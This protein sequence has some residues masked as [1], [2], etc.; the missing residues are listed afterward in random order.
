MP[1][2]KF[3]YAFGAGLAEGDGSMKELLGGKGA[4][5]HEMTKIGLP[6]PAGFTITT[7]VC[8]LYYKNGK[9]WPEGLEAE[10]QKHIKNLEKVTKKT[11]GDPRDPLLVSVRSGAP[12]SMPGMME[13]I[14]NLG[15]TDASV[16]G[17]ASKTGNRRFALD[18]YRRFIMMYSSIAM[19]IDREI[20]DKAFEEIK[21]TKTR[22][23]I[24]IP[25]EQKV[26]DTDVNEEELGELIKSFKKIYRDHIG[27]DFPQDSWEQL[28]GA[29][30]AVFDSWMAEKAVTYRKVEK[31]VG[32]K[33][34]AV[35]IV[36]MV[37]GNKGDSSGTG[38]CFTRDPNTGENIFYGD[39]LINAQGEDVVAGIR[40]PIKLAELE[41]LDPKV[42]KQ[43]VDIRRKLE[44]HYR[45]MQDLEF[46]VEEGK[47][48][49]LQCRTGKRSPIAA[50]RIAVDLVKEKLITKEEA[51]LRI[52]ASDIEGIF[53]PM[54]DKSNATALKKSFLV[55]GID[56]V[57]GAAVGRVV[58]NA[59]VA[60]EWEEKGEKIILVRK[61]TSPEDVGGMHAA[62]GI[63]T[64]TGGKTSHAAV[65]ARG[66][67]KCCIVGCE[68]L[69]ID[70]ENR[71]FAV[72]DK[73]V[74]EGDYITLDGNTGNVYLGQL[75]LVKPEPPKAYKT[76]MSWVDRTRKLKVR[77]NADTPYDAEKAR[78]LG[79]EGIGLC[80][81]EHMFFDSE[82]RILAIREM[83]IADDTESRKKALAKLLPFQ[84]KDF[85]GIFRVM[86]G[87]PV[88]IRLIDPPLHEFVPHDEEGQR[89]LADA[90]GVPIEKVIQRVEQL[91]ELNPMLGHRGC[92]L[93]ITYPE[94]LDMQVTAII[95]AACNMTKNG[96]KVL[97][98]IMI[99]L[100]IDDKE[101]KILESRARE[102]AAAIIAASE[103]PL[104]YMIGTMIEVPRAALL[105]D[106]IAKVAEFFSFGTN[107][108]TQMTLG[109]S[110]DDAG[111]F[112]PDYID[113]KKGAIFKADPFQNIDQDGVGMLIRMGIEKGR[114]SRPRLKVGICGE[115]GGDPESVKFCHRVGMNYVSS[116]PFRV[117]V[118]RL[119][120]AQAVIEDAQ[121]AHKSTRKPGRPPKAAAS[122]KAKR[123]R[124]RPRGSKNK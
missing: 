92:R 53:Y 9:K 10:I 108:L 48:Y 11:L 50:F 123:P 87:L 82:E 114:S 28:K 18:A 103:V 64:A 71:H 68:K 59:K 15:L 107:D 109:L 63:L 76:L 81:T 7:E 62:Q 19:G 102:I 113:E 75:K 91:H 86:D 85:E 124:G 54:I 13:T 40:T 14:L 58:F 6:V 93:T 78:E 77:T 117:P 24:G 94:I 32:I 30:N 73:I 70:Y 25:S 96:I 44:R 118:S 111:R 20:F 41:K 90:I 83:I 27:T 39:Y 56:A 3:V 55:Q 97:P 42:Y 84:T 17:L 112:L 38:V 110:R 23:R 26:N 31:L 89:E 101:L 34:T 80:R 43:L 119:A 121:A 95:T 57:P 5:L 49:M 116:S 88:T 69:E 8:E 122:S 120:A 36:Q 22:P 46:T 12:V 74:K 2:R 35:N 105:A 52:K 4:G 21:E 61:E 51:I 79:A 60:E 100:V 99:P 1:R 29:I 45:D 47:L 67:G 65:V 16:E 66:W 98:E 106:R 72:G 104:K 37:F 115:H 33:G